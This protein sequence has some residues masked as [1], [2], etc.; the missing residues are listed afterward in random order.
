M[1]AFRL[2]PRTL[3][4]LAALGLALMTYVAAE[5]A[6]PAA[7]GKTHLTDFDIFHLAGRL[8]IE[9]ALD[10]AYDPDRF[11]AAQGRLP[12]GG[13]G[14][15]MYWSY[16]PPFDVVVA[17]LGLLPISLAFL[18]FVGGTLALYLWTLR[19]LAGDHFHL[20]LVLALPLLALIIRCGQNGLLTG[21]LA[22]LTCLMLIE[23]RRGAGVP[24]GL[25]IIKPHLALGLGLTLLL[26]QAWWGAAAVSILVAGAACLASTAALG[27]EVWGMFLAG[28]GSTR[29]ILA[30]GG[31]PNFRMTSAYALLQALGAPHGVAVAIHLAMAA[32]FAA[33]LVALRVA[34]REPRVLLGFG[35]FV[36]ATISPYNYDYD[37]PMVGVAAALLA[38]HVAARAGRGEAVLLCASA[39]AIGCHGLI[40]SFLID[41]APALLPS[42]HGTPVPFMAPVMLL[43]GVTL[44]RVLWRD[45]EGRLA[46]PGAVP[47]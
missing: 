33:M 8:A 6:W 5:L 43:V 2:A 9:G 38:G 25:M 34:G 22:G 32:A 12:A 16:P 27:P 24:L 15:P 36:S 18:G 1:T 40:T 19:R 20:V 39:L 4:L 31:F 10:Q 47:A 7:F 21:S 3:W 37:L 45:G 26:R 44:A 42:L 41:R 13:G 46:M 35:L 17:L 11:Q 28:M 23:G 29:D 14:A 30:D